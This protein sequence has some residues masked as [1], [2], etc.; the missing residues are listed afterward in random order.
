MRLLSRRAKE[1]IKTGLAM[2][3]AFGIALGMGWE[4]P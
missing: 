1:A 2:A 3:I 4:N